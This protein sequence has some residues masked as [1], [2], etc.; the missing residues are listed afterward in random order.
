MKKV[1]IKWFDIKNGDII[2]RKF[3]GILENETEETVT[4]K[5]NRRIITVNKS[6][7]FMN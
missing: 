5:Y 4:F 3:Y 1:S 7:C 2:L 6:D